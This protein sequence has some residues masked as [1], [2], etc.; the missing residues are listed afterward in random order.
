VDSFRSV[1]RRTA[2]GKNRSLPEAD[3]R[4]I[5]EAG[6]LMVTSDRPRKRGRRLTPRT[7]G[8]RRAKREDVILGKGK[9]SAGRENFQQRRDGFGRKSVFGEVFG[10]KWPSR[11]PFSRAVTRRLRV[12]ICFG[13]RF[14]TF[15]G[16]NTVKN[17]PYVRNVVV[18]RKKP[19]K[20]YFRVFNR[21]KYN[22]QTH[23]KK[24]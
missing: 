20:P 24:I 12:E 10:E 22:D 23:Q 5:L 13:T 21:N 2:N 9:K 17:V 1:L 19:K 11:G 4:G 16:A 3:R 6:D 18:H 8:R 15:F 7:R 14:D